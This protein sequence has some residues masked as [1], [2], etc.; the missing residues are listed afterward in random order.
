VAHADYHLFY[1][2]KKQ[3][4]S[5]HFSYETEVI[6]AAET[7]VDGQDS[8]LLLSVLQKLEQRAKTFIGLCEEYVE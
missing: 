8:E 6:A 3:L 5:S 7:W 1:G 4:K 2:L